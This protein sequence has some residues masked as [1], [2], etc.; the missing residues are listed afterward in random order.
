[1]LAVEGSVPYADYVEAWRQEAQMWAFWDFRETDEPDEMD[2]PVVVAT[3]LDVQMAIPKGTP[4]PPLEGNAAVDV[5]PDLPTLA[6]TPELCGLE[7][8]TSRSLM[9]EIIDTAMADWSTNNLDAVVL[10]H[11]QDQCGD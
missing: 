9:N 2:S 3:P 8:E 6:G 1:M 4:A 10:D 11:E 5:G 7:D